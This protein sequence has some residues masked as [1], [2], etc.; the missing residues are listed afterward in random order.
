[1]IPIIQTRPLQLTVI[2]GKTERPHQ[3]QSRSCRQTKPRHVAGVWRNLRLNQDNVKHSFLSSRR[4]RQSGSDRGISNYSL[5]S[6][7][8]P[9]LVAAYGGYLILLSTSFASFTT[10][11][12]NLR[13]PSAVFSVAIALSFTRYLN[14]FSSN[15][16]RSTCA[17]FAFSGLSFRSTGPVDFDNSSINSGLIVSRSQPASSM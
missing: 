9:V 6:S 1:F 15:S 2:Q 10:S 12:A 11:A 7:P 3:M 4:V 8:R 16:T 17:D 14:F 13:I 5:P